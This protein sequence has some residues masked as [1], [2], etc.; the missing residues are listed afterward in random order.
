MND[1]L[2][3]KKLLS[4]SHLSDSDVLFLV[5]ATIFPSTVMTALLFQHRSRTPKFHHLLWHFQKLFISIRTIKQLLTDCDTVLFLCICQ[6]MRHKFCSNM[7]L[8]QFVGQN[9]VAQTF[10]D[11]YFFVTPR[12][13]RGQFWWITASAFSTWSFS[14]DVEGHPDLG[15]SSMDVLPDLKHWYHSW[16]CVQLNT[17]LSISLLQHLKSLLKLFPNLKQNLTQMRCSSRSLIFK[18]AKN[19]VGY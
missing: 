7:M 5:V 10:T 3:L 14:I 17:I 19:R 4:P 16:H 12:T 8:L 6:Q 11:S 18:L 13:V 15:S 1:T 2:P 9:Q